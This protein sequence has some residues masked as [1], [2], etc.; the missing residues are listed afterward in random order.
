M[1]E[2]KVNPGPFVL[3]SVLSGYPDQQ[4]PES[5]SSFLNEENSG[6]SENLRALLSEVIEK[7]D[8][9]DDLRS[10]YIALFDHS[11]NLNPLYESEYGRE[12]ALFKANEL[13]DI[14]GFYRAFGFELSEQGAR[15]MVDHVSVELEFYGL[16]AMKVRHLIDQQDHK[17]VE[18]V[19][20]GMKKFMESHLGRFVPAILER[21]GVKNSR[22][23]WEIFSWIDDVIKKECTRLEVKPERASWFCSQAEQEGMCCGSSVPLGK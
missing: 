11:K 14:A 3:A 23:Y 21:E 7:K 12:R 15:D 22:I 10:E 9:V 17:G 19:Q 18:I 4:F 20:D 1:K 2:Q 13:S 16:L 6:L 5:V 8:G